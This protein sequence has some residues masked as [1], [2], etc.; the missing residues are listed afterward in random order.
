VPVITLARHPVSAF[1]DQ[2]SLAAGRELAQKSSPARSGTDDYHVV[3]IAARHCLLLNVDI[4]GVP[5][6]VVQDA[7]DARD[8]LPISG[9]VPKL[10]L[11]RAHQM[12]AALYL[13]M[14][15]S[16]GTS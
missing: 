13:L 6:L 3:M 15:R 14:S 7:P 11:N 4:R 5:H 10:T 1:E 2:N 9:A 12:V 16:A 8:Y